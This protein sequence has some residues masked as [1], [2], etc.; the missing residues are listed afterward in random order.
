MGR[1]RSLARTCKSSR[2]PNKPRTVPAKMLSLQMRKGYPGVTFCRNGKKYIRRLGPVILEAFAGPKPEGMEACHID[3]D[4]L[5]NAASN[6]RWDTHQ[7]NCRDKWKHQT[8]ANGERN[9]NSKLKPSDVAAI[10]AGLSRG[11]VPQDLADRFGVSHVTIGHIRN[12]KTWKH[13]A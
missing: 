7:N 8:I 4:P 10:K 6:L 9:G 3:G 1:V 11:E 2:N 12:G 13:V 5:N